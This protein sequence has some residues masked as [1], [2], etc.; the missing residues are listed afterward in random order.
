MSRSRAEVLAAIKE[1]KVLIIDN[2]F[3]LATKRVMDF[4]TEFGVNP[5][6]ENESTDLRRRFNKLRADKRSPLGQDLEARESQL[7]QDIL[8]FIS[9]IAEQYPVEEELTKDERSNYPQK[10]LS[11]IDNPEPENIESIAKEDIVTTSESK[12]DSNLTP[13]EQEEI[14]FK[15]K[16]R[17]K[18]APIKTQSPNV[19]FKGTNIYKIYKGRSIDFSLNIPA[20]QIEFGEITSLVGENGNGKTTLIRIIAG[21]LECTKGKLEYPVLWQK[22]TLNW[23]RIKQQIAYIPPRIR[24]LE[25]FIN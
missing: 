25:W 13:L 7:T 6:A 24:T 4:A 11:E 12:I 5:Q 14:R 21:N 16:R 9:S 8:D 15:K 1:I 20:L 23:Y 17:K 10:E 2:E 18:Q 3:N 22:N 19:I